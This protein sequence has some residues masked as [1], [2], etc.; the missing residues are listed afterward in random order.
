MKLKEKLKYYP[1]LNIDKLKKIIDKYEYVSFDIFDTLINRDVLNPRDVFK[2]VAIKYFKERK[3]NFYIDRVEAEKNARKNT[4][5]E[6][7]SIDD[8]YKYLLKTKKYNNKDVAELKKIE[9]EIEKNLCVL[10]TEVYEL[11]EYCIKNNK[12]II[13][14]S[15]MYLSKSLIEEMINSVGYNRYEKIYLSREIGKKKDKTLFQFILDD[16][17]ITSKSIIHIGDSL[18]KDYIPAKKY[19]IKSILVPKRINKLNHSVIK[20]SIKD[21][22]FFVKSLDTF[23]NNRINTKIDKYY[24][25]GYESFGILLYKFCEYLHNEIEKK[26]IKD[27]FFFSRDG[28]IIKEAY[29]EIYNKDNKIK[30]HYLYVSRRSLRVPG[31]WI[32]TDFNDVVK[33]FPLAKILTVE[34]FIKNLGLDPSKYIDSL[35]KYNLNLDT[36]IKKKELTTNNNIKNFYKS[37]VKDVVDVSKQECHLLLEYFKQE[38]FKDNVAV[39]D[40]GWHGSLQFFID[41]I[42]KKCNYKLNMTGYYIGLARERKNNINAY[43]FVKDMDIKSDS[44]D[45]WKAFNGLIESIFSAQAGST[46]KLAKI[47]NKIVPIFYPYE[48]Q[49]DDKMEIEAINIKSIQDGAI[50]FVKDFKNSYVN[51]INSS[52]FTAFRKIYLTGV[53]PNKND[54]NMFANFRFLEEQ[55]DY[56]AKPRKSIYYLIHPKKLKND[57]MLSR[58]KIGF[59]KKILKVNI[60]Y[61]NIYKLLKKLSD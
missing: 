31:L 32:S 26:Q 38:N 6:E 22:M 25:F 1:R 44:C 3:N 46:E 8:I 14:I 30:S 45:S 5:K 58:W 10:K 57:L 33:T 41:K 40:I 19:S 2:L 36:I 35:K 52:S 55:I 47:N 7:I 17:N 34:T 23:I 48:Y 16:L 59:M 50:A 29:D 13:I 54:I 49:K 11:Y 60:S 37:I 15:N 61:L 56:L 12:K 18:K 53:F 39:V 43:G 51:I 20:H 24:N 21:D 42:A 4:N 28:Y 27:I 9:I